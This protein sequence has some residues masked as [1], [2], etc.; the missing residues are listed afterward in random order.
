MRDLLILDV[1]EEIKAQL[2]K[3]EKAGKKQRMPCHELAATR[4]R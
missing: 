3:I 2:R 4:D 1:P